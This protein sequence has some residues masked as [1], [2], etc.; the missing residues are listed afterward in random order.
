[1]R[2]PVPV[3]ETPLLLIGGALPVEQALVARDLMDKAD[4]LREAVEAD[5]TFLAVCG[6]YQLLGVLLPGTLR[7]GTA[8][9]SA[10]SR[11]R[12]LLATAG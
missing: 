6:G 12:T 1:M 11:S 7:R 4:A 9:G 5:V 2:D 3:D 8:R 10:R